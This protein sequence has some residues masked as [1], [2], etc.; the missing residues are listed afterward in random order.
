MREKSFEKILIEYKK[1]LDLFKE[2]ESKH[3]FPI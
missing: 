3:I 1:D 2:D